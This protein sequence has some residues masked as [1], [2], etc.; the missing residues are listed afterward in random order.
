MPAVVFAMMRRPWLKF[1][2]GMLVCLILFVP[3]I[4]IAVE[5]GEF[6]KKIYGG[7]LPYM[8]RVAL[9]VI[10]GWFGLWILWY[11]IGKSYNE[12]QKER[13]ARKASDPKYGKRAAIQR[14]VLGFITVAAVI[15][16]GLTRYNPDEAR[17]LIRSIAAWFR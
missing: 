6:L 12:L 16:Y 13:E 1:W 15:I 7:E 4:F 10:F 2:G 9:V 3:L 5:V 11:T 17:Q 14:W 8:A